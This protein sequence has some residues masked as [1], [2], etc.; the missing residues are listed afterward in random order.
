M[1]CIDKIANLREKVR[2]WRIEQLKIALIP[3]M[4]NLHAGH[5]SLVEQAKPIAD[6]TIVSIF[7]NP[8]QFVQGEDYEKYPRT[9]DNDLSRLENLGTDLV[10]KPKVKEMYP[11]GLDEKTQITLSN[12]DSVYCG[13]FRP[14][15]FAGVAKVVAKLFNVVQPDIAFFGEKDY[16]QLLVIKRLVEDLCMPIS[17]I[18][19]PTVREAD[20]LAMS[21]RNAYLS[22]D[23]RKVAPLLFKTLKEIAEGLNRGECNYTA[24]EDQAIQV[25][26][27][28]GF[29]SEYVK[30]RNASDLGE[31]AGGDLVVIAAAWLG[32]ARL[33]DNVIIKR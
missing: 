10:F 29:K 21:S 5:L 31:P 3:T 14:G 32:G 7:V 20:G 26:E 33:I 12:L 1:Q 24:M 2:G 6:R 8:T 28:A 11:G 27:Q 13:A 15:H 22:D 30:I 18:G 4:G 25:I 17:V 23:E 9:L 19:L 16:Q